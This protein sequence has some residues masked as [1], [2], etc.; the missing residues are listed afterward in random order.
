MQDTRNVIDTYKGQPMEAI[1]HDLDAH[2]VSLEI[3]VE[4]LT[5]DFNMGTIIRSAN[6]FGV[7]HIHIIGRRQWN[8][9]G[10][11][12]T[13]KYLHLH[14]YESVDEFVVAMADKQVIAI[15]N[16]EGSVPLAGV[17]FTTDTVLV[18]GSEGEGLSEDML[19]RSAQVVAIE[20][21]GSTRSL[22]VG[23]AAGVVMYEWVR[24]CVLTATDIAR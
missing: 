8:K 6:A 1:I 3:A 23:V 11:M 24:Q 12:M 16:V 20:Q 7:R 9:R 5:R 4:N 19:N 10:A 15:D 22:N 17:A 18:F 21:F 14:Y 2:G 13:D